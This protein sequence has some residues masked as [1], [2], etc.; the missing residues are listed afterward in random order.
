MREKEQRLK[1]GLDTA[2]IDAIDEDDHV[3]I[4]ALIDSW[5][6]EK[7]DSSGNRYEEPTDSESDDDERFSADAINK[8]MDQ[9]EKKFKRHEELLDKFTKTGLLPCTTF[10]LHLFWNSLCELTSL[11]SN[12]FVVF[13]Y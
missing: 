1:V 7:G 2:D 9:F 6:R 3:G 10:C 4:D 8:R 12:Y 11:Y 5:A 13:V